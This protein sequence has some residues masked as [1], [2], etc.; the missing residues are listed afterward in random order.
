MDFDPMND[1][2]GADN[3]MSQDMSERDSINIVPS[4]VDP[5]MKNA[6]RS[7]D[8]YLEKKRQ[9]KMTEELF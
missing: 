6:R 4:Q 8:D 9:A 2:L 5:K 3:Y 1:N 7:I